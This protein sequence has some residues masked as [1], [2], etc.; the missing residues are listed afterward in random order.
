M[1]LKTTHLVFAALLLLAPTGW[2]SG[3]SEFPVYQGP[4]F[5][6]HPVVSG[7]LV[8]WNDYRD[9]YWDIYGK[10]LS[11]PNDLAITTSR[12]SSVGGIDGGFLVWS[13]SRDGKADVY[14]KHLPSGPEVAICLAPS[15]Q[16][17]ADISG[18]YVVWKDGRNSPTNV[19]PE[20]WN[21]DIYGYELQTGSEIPIC[22]NPADQINP[23]ID[24]NIVVWQDGRNRFFP[25]FTEWD[26]YGYDLSTEQEFPVTNAPWAQAEPAISGNVVVWMDVRNDNWDIYGKDLSTGIE[27]PICRDPFGQGQP[28]IDGNIVV[29]VDYR[30][31]TPEGWGQ[32]DIYG[33]DL[34]THTE[35][36]ISLDPS[37][38]GPPQIS[39]NLVVWHVRRNGD[40]DI[41]GA[42]IPEPA[43]TSLLALAALPLLRRKRRSGCTR[44]GVAEI[45]KQSHLRLHLVD[46]CD[47]QGTAV[48]L[49]L[50][51]EVRID[52]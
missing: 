14:G 23:R 6:L 11:E 29:W 16:G 35:F 40:R 46:S 30:N 44:E 22:T 25:P 7:E 31:T 45:S 33:Y 15:P 38:Q 21:N 50:G 34:L 47:V 9:G 32:G 52:R 24:G 49:S 36:P 4:G 10:Y 41:Y 17:P 18:A 39:G 28:S 27:F 48:V 5:Q 26:I 1:W 8:V 37:D 12:E 2:T 51:R 19:P 20:F 3:F 43:S 13:D 42:Y